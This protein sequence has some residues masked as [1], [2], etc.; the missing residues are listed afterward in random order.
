[1]SVRVH[2][3]T[4]ILCPT[5]HLSVHW[6]HPFA[7]VC[8][9]PTHAPLYVHCAHTCAWVCTVPT[10]APE[11]FLCLPLRPSVYCAHPCTW[12]CTVPPLRPSVYFAHPCA[13]VRVGP[14]PAACWLGIKPPDG[15]TLGLKQL[16][17]GYIFP[18][19]IPVKY[20]SALT[21]FDK[22]RREI[23][24]CGEWTM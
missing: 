20:V 6:A 23:T 22:K 3:C 15:P 4:C 13:S 1:M 21:F 9:V 12:V 18:P 14:W 17:L 10:P 11:C 8:T 5:L 16:S 19:S 2:S 24:Y 7:L